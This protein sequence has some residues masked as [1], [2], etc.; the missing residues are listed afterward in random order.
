VAGRPIRLDSLVA[1]SDDI[2]S[3]PLGEELAMMDAVG[4]KYYV[5][6]DIGRFVWDR[7]GQARP[8]SDLLADVRSHYD[9]APE[10]CEQDVL[11]LLGELY[12]KGI[13]AVRAP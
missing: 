3:A 11:A 12:E 2:V 10:Q 9:V 4:G 1:R 5:L 7:L 8:V 6:D 13:V